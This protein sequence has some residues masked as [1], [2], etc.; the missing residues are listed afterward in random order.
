MSTF[1]V[2]EDQMMLH[3]KDA[4]GTEKPDGKGNIFVACFTTAHARMKL[5]DELVKVGDRALYFDTGNTL[6]LHFQ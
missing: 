2:N 5:Y 6:I 1:L 3:Y 4:D